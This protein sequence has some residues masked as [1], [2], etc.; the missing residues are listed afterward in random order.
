VAVE[1]IPQIGYLIAIDI[2]E[3][4]FLASAAGQHSGYQYVYSNEGKLYFKHDYVL[5]LDDSIGDIKSAISDKQRAL[6]RLS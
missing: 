1:Y 3:K 2:S 5:E 4:H 6:V